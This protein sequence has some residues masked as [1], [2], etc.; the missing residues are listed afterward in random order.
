MR[1]VSTNL[2]NRSRISVGDSM[3]GQV[4]ITRGEYRGT[5]VAIK[6]LNKQRVYE[7]QKLRDEMR[8]V[9]S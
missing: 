2:L 8:I 5:P 7:D 9:S 3:N 4:F 1:A 6:L